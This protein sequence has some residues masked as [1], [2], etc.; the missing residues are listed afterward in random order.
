M[1]LLLQPEH[2]SQAARHFDATRATLSR[3]GQWFGAYPYGHLTIVDPTWDSPTSGMEYPTLFTVGTSWLMPRE[4][5][6]VEDTVVHEAGHQWWYGMVGNN[7]F[8]DAWMDEGI[9]QYANARADS[10]ALPHGRTVPR[11]FGGFIPWPIEDAEWN[12]LVDGDVLTSYRR[13]AATET[14]ST[15]SYQYWLRSWTPMAYAKPALWLH[16]LERALGWETMQR[17]LSTFFER[18][19]F[20]H[21]KPEDFFQ[22]A[23]EVSGRD[24]TP[25]FD[26][27]YRGS[28][29]FDYGVDALSSDEVDGGFRTDVIVRRHG[30]GVFPVTLLITFADGKQRR[31]AWDGVARWHKETLTYAVK[32]VSAQVDPDQV[33]LLDTNFTNN[34]FTTEPQAAR[35]AAKWAAIW[36]VW[37]QDHLLTWAVL[38]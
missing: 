16:T 17:I 19:K 1:R 14:Q 30:D 33:L 21:P 31:L 36:M 6:Y 27:V 7:E 24:L 15:P 3:Y 4:D 28:A 18:W 25:F 13:D 22:V 20:R 26:Q 8:E 2:L 5:T 38:L 29:I 32:A 23:N 9:N 11:F 37:L 35:A 10:E 12:R 34:S